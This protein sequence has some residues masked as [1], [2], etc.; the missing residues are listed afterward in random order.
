MAAR[1]THLLLAA[2]LLAAAMP[3]SADLYGREGKDKECLVEEL[4]NLNFHTHIKKP[5]SMNHVKLIEFYKDDAAN[6]KSFTKDYCSLAKQLRGIIKVTAINCGKQKKICDEYSVTSFPTLKVIPPG[7][8]GVTEYT[9][10]RNDKAVYTWALKFMTHFV[11]KITADNIDAFLNK[12]AGKFKALL[13]TDKPKT[14]LMWRGLSVDLKGKMTLGIVNKDEKGVVSRY[15]VSKFPT[16]LV[17]KPGQKKP[18]KYDDKFEVRE[19]FEF[20]NKYQETFALENNAADEELALKKPWLAEAIPELTSLSAQDVCYGA[21]AWCVIVSSKATADGKLD[22]NVYDIVMATK[23]KHSGEK[24]KLA[25]M[26]I[27]SDRESA[28]V[29]ALDI[30]ATDGAK[31][32]VLRTGKR[33]RFA[34]DDTALSQ[35]SLERFLERVLNSD[36]QYTNLKEGPPALTE[37]KMP[38]PEKKKK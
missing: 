16:I 28:F 6:A 9:G 30:E 23:S 20:L 11:E 15:K 34:K 37:M 21:D 24:V 3:A 26:W 8:F 35:S 19:I 14:P 10:E 5:D 22:K 1:S 7:G 32:A 27:N 17:V 25:F 31:V 2:A 4:N 29:K 38:E 18:I 36:V 12:E 13:F 33:T